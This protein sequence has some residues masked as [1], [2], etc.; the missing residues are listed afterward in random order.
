[1]ERC[2]LNSYTI[3]CSGLAYHFPGVDKFVL[4]KGA[5]TP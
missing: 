4:A 5:E 3:S 1:M 2:F